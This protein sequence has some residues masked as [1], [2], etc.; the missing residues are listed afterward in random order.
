MHNEKNDPNGPKYIEFNEEY[1]KKVDDLA[2]KLAEVATNGKF[3]GDL[4]EEEALLALTSI[5]KCYLDIMIVD[6]P[7]KKDVG[8][9][10]Y[11]CNRI[12][13]ILGDGVKQYLYMYD[14]MTNG[15]RNN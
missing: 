12:T 5:V 4:S 9:Y 1:Y 8:Y 15:Y 10:R 13:N 3:T 2:A 6:H 14:S 11:L 7:T